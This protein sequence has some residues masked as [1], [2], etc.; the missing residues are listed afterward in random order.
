MNSQIVRTAAVVFLLL[1]LTVISGCASSPPATKGKCTAETWRNQKS[2]YGTSL[3]SYPSEPV[4][5]T[6][7]YHLT[8]RPI[9]EPLVEG[10]RNGL[11]E[12]AVPGA[13]CSKD[14]IVS[15]SFPPGIDFDGCNE[16]RI[17]GTPQEPGNW[18]VVIRFPEMVCPCGT[19]PPRNVP[20]EF[21]IE[22]VDPNW[23]W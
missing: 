3:D 2:W 9:M 20:V 14:L 15:G 17:I 22:G 18:Y 19:R 16:L 13:V 6:V 1:S 21:Q 10:C 7:G 4:K 11:K 8:A 12:T 23:L 5:G